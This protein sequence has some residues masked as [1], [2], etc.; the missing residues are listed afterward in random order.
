MFDI[1]CSTCDLVYIV[2]TAS[3]TGF[4]NTDA[5]PLGRAV[6]PAGHEVVVDFGA[7]RA[8]RPEA[9]PSNPALAA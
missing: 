3:L 6:C 8:R 5:G 7:G 9:S 2:G 4:A 1:Y